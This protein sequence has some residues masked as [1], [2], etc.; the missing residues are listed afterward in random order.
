MLTLWGRLGTM[1]PTAEQQ[2]AVR[3]TPLGR[4][5]QQRYNLAQRLKKIGLTE[6]EYRRLLDRQ[7]GVCYVCKTSEP[8]NRGKSCTL[9]IDHDHETGKVRKLLCGRCNKVLGA[10]RDDPQLLEKLAAYVREH[11]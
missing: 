2:R 6:P 1:R 7:G 11:N 8:W 5:R 3:K 4:Q 9:C 10:V